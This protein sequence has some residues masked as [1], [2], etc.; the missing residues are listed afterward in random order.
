MANNPPSRR[1]R[2]ALF[3]RTRGVRFWAATITVVSIGVLFAGSQ[4]AHNRGQTVD[5]YTGFGQWLGALGSFIAAG[6][7]LWIS[8]S[9]RRHSTAERKAQRRSRTPTLRGRPG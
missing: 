4:I 6:A 9:D 1:A 3:F 8:V 2:L 5:W 7:A